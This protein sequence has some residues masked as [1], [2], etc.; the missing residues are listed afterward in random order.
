MKIAIL[1]ATGKTGGHALQHALADGHSVRVLVRTPSKLETKHERLEVVQGDATKQADCARVVAG[2]DAVIAALGP[3]GLGA[4]TLRQDAAKAITAAMVEQGVKRLVWLSAFG[5]GDNIAQA[6]RTTFIGTLF[7]KTLLK[8]TYVDAAAAEQVLRGSG[9][10][11]VLCR[12]PELLD[13]P[14]RGG[15]VEVPEDQ[16]LPKL[17]IPREDVAIWMLKAATTGAFDRQAV[18]IC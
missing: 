5:V 6:K 14:A 1:G 15:V 13:K 2:C 17:R 11:F 18:T 8:K 10:D 3:E 7:M 9:L 16:K 4:T 12:P